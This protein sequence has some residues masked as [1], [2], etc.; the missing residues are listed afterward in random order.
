[1]V[2]KQDLKLL[3]LIMVFNNRM[4]SHK[5]VKHQALTTKGF[6]LGKSFFFGQIPFIQHYTSSKY[7]DFDIELVFLILQN[8]PVTKE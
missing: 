6:F 2:N 5:T 3:N 4:L 1:M 7:L 8:Y